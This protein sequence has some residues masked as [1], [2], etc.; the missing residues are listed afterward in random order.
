[1]TAFNNK[2]DEGSKTEWCSP[3]E[4]VSALG[5]FDL[6]PCAPVVPPF[7]LAETTFNVLTDGLKREWPRDAFV[8]LNPPYDVNL[9][10][11]LKRLYEHPGGGIALIFARTDTRYFESYVWTA[12][13]ILFTKRLTFYH[14]DGRKAERNAGAPSVLAAYG[15]KAVVRLR[16]SDP[17]ILPGNYIDLGAN[18]VRTGAHRRPVRRGLFDAEEVAA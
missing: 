7:K 13:A 18:R 12:D 11:W 1:M 16:E 14:V 9:T 5:P 3:P 17:K 10:A 4:I 15:Q 8:W 6:D 2:L